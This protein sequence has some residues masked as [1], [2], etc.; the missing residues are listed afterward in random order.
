MVVRMRDLS[1]GR[2][3]IIWKVKAEGPC[4]EWGWMMSVG[5]TRVLWGGWEPA[6]HPY[7]EVFSGGFGRQARGV[8][9]LSSDYGQVG[10]LLVAI[11]GD[12]PTLAFAKLVVAPNDW[13]SCFPADL[14]RAKSCQFR[15]T[16]GAVK[17]IEGNKPVRVPGVPASVTLAASAGRL[18]VVPADLQWGR[19]G[20]ARLN[21]PVEIRDA[22]TG[23]VA[24]RIHPRGEVEAVALSE[25]VVAALVREAGA[26]RL[27]VYDIR[28]GGLRSTVKLTG[29]VSP[30]LG[31]AGPIVV[32]QVG[33]AIRMLRAGERTT[34]LVAMARTE[35]EGLSIEGKRVIWVENRT[36]VSSVQALTLRR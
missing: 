7:G 12:G 29:N 4:P 23:G 17:R 15:V 19:A 24:L 11:V 36:P 26:V 2:E 13:E 5:G 9:D 28:T 3:S 21:G 20:H 8:E 35:P 16:S 32:Y 27:D 14:P 1:S 34:A 22:R 10:D 6:N 31:A 33:K 30:N 18:A 25:R